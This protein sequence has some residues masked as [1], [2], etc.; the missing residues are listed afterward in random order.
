[1]STTNANVREAYEEHRI[2]RILD[3]DP[4]D[5]VDGAVWY[6]SDTGEYRGVE[7]GTTVIF[8]TTEA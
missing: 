4:D 8:D 7:D 2:V 1:M 6:R 3:E 5:P